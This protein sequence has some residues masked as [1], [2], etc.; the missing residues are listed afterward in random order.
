MKNKNR[1]L[2]SISFLPIPFPDDAGAAGSAPADTATGGT[3]DAA[4]A[5]AGGEGEG[6]QVLSD[7]E[8]IDQ[9]REGD[10]DGENTNDAEAAGENT[11]GEN[12]DGA[13]SEKKEHE[14]S[15]SSDNEGGDDTG[16]KSEDE[17]VVPENADDYDFTLPDIGLKNEKGEPFQFD[18]KDPFIAK[19]REIAHADGMSQ[20]GLSDALKL[21]AEVQ[22][23]T[24]DALQQGFKAA[25]ETRMTEELG[26]LSYNDKAGKEIKG[27]DRVKGILSALEAAGGK[28]LRAALV[29]AFV[30]A[31]AVIALEKLVGLASEGKI[32][33]GKTT[34]S[35]DLDGMSGED[36]LLHIRSNEK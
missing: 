6:A 10:N 9:A 28:D 32:G 25:E 1:F 27:E 7:A 5:D 24:N 30:N 20:K 18:P 36:A 15:S 2:N 34:A 29:P 12:T 16:A 31:D 8:R 11:S 33:N 13:D 21:Y 35:T 19:M 26:K 3:G 22:K 23:D 4:P 14:D 17:R